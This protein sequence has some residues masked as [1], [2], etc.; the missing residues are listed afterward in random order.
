[1]RSLHLIGF[2]LYNAN[3]K[4]ESAMKEIFKANTA[5]E[6]CEDLLKIFVIEFRIDFFKKTEFVGKDKRIQKGCSVIEDLFMV[7]YES[8]MTE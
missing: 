5:I 2:P 1:M 3:K 8:N 6:T 7:L 4:G